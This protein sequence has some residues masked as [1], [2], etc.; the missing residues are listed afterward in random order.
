MV[1]ND[2]EQLFIKEIMQEHG[3]FLHSLFVEALESNNIKD[4][5]TLISSITYK[6]ERRGNNFV[7]SFTFP[8]YGRALEI[9]YYKSKNS[10]LA[11]TI[12]SN[13]S[14]LTKKA[15]NKKRDY[16][17]Y[18]RNL[19]GSQNRL[20]G[21]ASYRLVEEEILRLKKILTEAKLD[22]SYSKILLK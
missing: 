1:D 17:W 6:V 8:G 3:Q 4:T 2:I 10:Q 20:I 11:N 12:K 16:R 18:S 5:G 22:G 21:R 13:R 7:L 15:K 9:R 19:Y 14:I